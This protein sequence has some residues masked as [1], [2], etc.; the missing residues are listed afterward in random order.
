M[1]TDKVEVSAASERIRLGE[2]AGG[3]EA[4]PARAPSLRIGRR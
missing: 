2:W 4:E 3:I 1:S